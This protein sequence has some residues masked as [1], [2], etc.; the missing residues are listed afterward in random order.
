M[1]LADLFGSSSNTNTSTDLTNIINTATQ[2]TL[3]SQSTDASGIIDSNQTVNFDNSGIMTNVT[4]S[5]LDSINIAAF[6]DATVNA[7]MQ[8]QMLD[9]VT[10]ALQQANVSGFPSLGSTVNDSNVTTNIKNSIN[11]NFNQDAIAKLVT[12]IQQNQTVN[13]KNTGVQSGITVTQAGKAIGEITNKMSTDI[14]TSLMATAGVKDTVAQTQTNAFADII[15]AIGGLFTGPM[16]WVAII[17]GVVFMGLI[18]VV[19]VYALVGGKS[20]KRSDEYSDERDDRSDNI[21]DTQQNYQ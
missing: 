14:A 8:A 10:K 2:S 9:N 3:I 13:D 1:G 7:T 19:I 18:G 15:S 4:I 17:I 16:M 20:P 21:D 11:S 6:Q 5:Q 12:S